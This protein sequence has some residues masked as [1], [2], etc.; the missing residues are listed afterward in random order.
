MNVNHQVKELGHS[1]LEETPSTKLHISILLFS[2]LSFLVLGAIIFQALEEDFE[3]E[4]RKLAVNLKSDFLKHH[5]NY[6]L[7]EVEMFVQTMGYFVLLGIPA[8]GNR[9]AV[10]SWTFFNSFVTSVIIVT[11]IGYGTVF[12]RTTGGQLFCIVFAAIGIPLTIIVLNCISKFI[13]LPFE[14]LG[15]YLQHKGVNESYV[16]LWKMALFIITGTL[17]FLALPPFVFTS[18]ENWTYIEGVYY[19]FTTI[20]TIGLG[21]YAIASN[22]M[23]ENESVTY[24]IL[25]LIWNGHGLVWLAIVFN[26]I[27]KFFHVMELKLTEDSS[28]VELEREEKKTDAENQFI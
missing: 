8:T 28:E 10:V 17:L 6:T 27:T 22:P 12:P 9:T 2:Y 11:T 25:L 20:S 1:G 19:S 15:N 23:K 18:L 13:F 21:D 7:H 14:K 5:A 16:T 24:S 4:Q 3:V 26:L